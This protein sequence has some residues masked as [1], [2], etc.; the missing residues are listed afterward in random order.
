MG[1][2]VTNALAILLA[3]LAGLTPLLLAWRERRP[4]AIALGFVAS[5]W[6]AAIVAGALIVA[7][8]QADIWVVTIVTAV[9]LWGGFIMPALLTTLRARGLMWPVALADAGIWLVALL[10]QAAVLRIVGLSAP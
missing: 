4:G 1:Y 7:P 3:G 8:V 6:I 5:T 2:I 10:L 9:I